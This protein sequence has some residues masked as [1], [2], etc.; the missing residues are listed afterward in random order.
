MADKQRKPSSCVSADTARSGNDLHVSASIVH[1]DIPTVMLYRSDHGTVVPDRH[2]LAAG[3]SSQFGN[4][5][6]SLNAERATQ[7]QRN[8]QICG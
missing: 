4:L 2:P 3:P 6:L 7:L 1:A 8:N 5:S